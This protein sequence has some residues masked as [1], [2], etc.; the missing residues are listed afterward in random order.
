MSPVPFCRQLCSSKRD[1]R[2]ERTSVGSCRTGTSC[3]L[4]QQTSTSMIDQESRSAAL[5][6]AIMILAA[7]ARFLAVCTSGLRLGRARQHGRMQLPSMCWPHYTP[8]QHAVSRCSRG[9]AQFCCEGVHAADRVPQRREHARRSSPRFVKACS[10]L[11]ITRSG[12]TS[13]R[14]RFRRHDAKR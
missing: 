6:M 5:Q 14:I 13:L 10:D 8:P 9:A 3:R 2:A 4:Q 12:W 7:P 11:L 1:C